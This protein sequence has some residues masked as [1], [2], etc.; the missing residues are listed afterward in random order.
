MLHDIDYPV[1]INPVF[2]VAVRTEAAMGLAWRLLWPCYHWILNFHLAHLQL[3]DI[4]LISTLR[5]INKYET[6]WKSLP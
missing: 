2:S 1:S 4:S 3:Q 6:F 5:T